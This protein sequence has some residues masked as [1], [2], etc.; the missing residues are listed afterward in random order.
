[1]ETLWAP[2]RIKYVEVKKP[3]G[4]IF[5][6]K[7]AADDDEENLIL[8]RDQLGFIILNA[9][10]YNNGHLMAAPYRHVGAIADLSDEEKLQLMQ[11]VDLAI[12]VISRTMSPDG[13]N[14][15]INLGR[16]AGAGVVD[17]VHIHV[18]PRWNGD[19]NFMPVIADTKVLPEALSSTYKKLKQELERSSR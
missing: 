12:G 14:V 13:F 15:G 3:E 17:H 4:C 8:H 19:T 2:W 10:P 16:V 7:S 9:F 18:V 5:C 1:M 6:D 11:L